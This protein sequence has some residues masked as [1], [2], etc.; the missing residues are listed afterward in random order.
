MAG[1]NNGSIEVIATGGTAPYR[2]LWSNDAFEAK[3][4]NLY[5][6][7][8]EVTVYD[9]NGCSVNMFVPLFNEKHI[10]VTEDVIQPSCQDETLG[11]IALSAD[12]G[13]APYAYEWSTGATTS[14]IQNLSDGKYSVEVMDANGC[15]FAKE[16][17]I[18]TDAGIEV[19][20]TVINTNCFND[21]EGSIDLTISNGCSIFA[22]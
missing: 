18:T 16:Y 13:T 21:A 5:A 2:Y 22:S 11:S 19:T 9:A 8:Y 14:A 1:K 6:G 7:T 17:L 20:S 15:S 10:L 12:G 4:S 3:V